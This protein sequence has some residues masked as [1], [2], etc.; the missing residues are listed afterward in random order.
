MIPTVH[1]G[2]LLDQLMPDFLRAYYE[3]LRDSTLGM[4]LARGAF[5]SLVGTAISR[6]LVQISAI[7]VARMLGAESY[8]EFGMI[9]STIGVFGVFAGFGL[10]LTTTKYVAE[11]RERNKARAGRVLALSLLVAVMSSGLMSLLLLILAPWLAENTLAAP[12]LVPYLR[13]G[14]LLLFFSAMNGAETGSLA[15]FED[16]KAIATVNFWAGVANFPLMIGCT[17]FWGL[18]GALVSLTTGMALNLGLNVWMVRHVA[19]RHSIIYDFQHCFEE[20]NVLWKF[21][22]P[23]ALTGALVGPVTWITNTM[24]V[25]QPLGYVE[26]GIFTAADQWRTALMFIPRILTSVFLP[27]FSDLNARAAYEDDSALDRTILR[28]QLVMGISVLPIGTLMVAFRQPIWR[29]YGSGYENG[30]IAFTGTVCAAMIA[31]VVA[32]IGPVVQ[33]KDDAWFG[34]LIN[35]V[36]GVTLLLTA[37]F[38]V[39]FGASGLAL[40]Y[41]IAYTVMAFAFGL[42]F[43]RRFD[44]RVITAVVLP[45]L[46]VILL[47]VICTCF[48]LLIFVGKWNVSDWSLRELI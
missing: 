41:V 16:F 2:Q 4:R 11:F 21:S 40:S 42:F 9:R 31:S 38:L 47:Y 33:A 46:Y 12:H 18:A 48:F 28:G 35:A 19:K 39:N 23:A 1:L 36:H 3:Q 26:L 10:G 32:I 13:L 37:L 30:E 45:M 20:L 6:G 15:G 34:F 25:K 43:R 29:L 5:W 22:L 24:L 7:F 17:Y 44:K 8:G 14:G 27:I